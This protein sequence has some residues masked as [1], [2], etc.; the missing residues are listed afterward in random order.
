[1]RKDIN[2]IKRGEIYMANIPKQAGSI[3]YGYKP[4][5]IVS[6]DKCNE[7]S[8][9]FSAFVITS[10]Q[11]KSKLP[12]HVDIGLESGLKL[13]SIVLCE[14]PRSFTKDILDYKVG[15]CDEYIMNDINEAA[16]K[17]LGIKSIYIINKLINKHELAYA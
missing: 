16:A 6:N 10:R 11:T 12:T 15:D 5:I 9:V 8:D 4:I 2:I 17:Q 3:Q 1:M 7:H 14:Q 13:P